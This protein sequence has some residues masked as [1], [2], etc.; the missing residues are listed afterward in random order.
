MTSINLWWW[1]AF[2]SLWRLMTHGFCSPPAIMKNTSLLNE[3]FVAAYIASFL[4]IFIFVTP[5]LVLLLL[6]LP[7]I[8]FHP[9]STI[10]TEERHIIQVQHI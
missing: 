7:I 2:A 10:S 9:M 1:Y 5:L 8:L 6:S 4:S 3:N